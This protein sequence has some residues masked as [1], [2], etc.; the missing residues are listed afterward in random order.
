MINYLVIPTGGFMAVPSIAGNV[1]AL[2][3]YLKNLEIAITQTHQCIDQGKFYPARDILNAEQN[4]LAR[5]EVACGYPIPQARER[6]AACYKRLGSAAQL[7]YAQATA[8]TAR[9]LIVKYDAGM[10]NTIELRGSAKANF[11]WEQGKALIFK[12]ND[13]WETDLPAR[14]AFEYK[15]TLRKTDGSVQWEDLPGNGNR[16]CSADLMEQTIFPIFDLL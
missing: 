16:T 3:Y 6:I 8:P 12:G 1:T 7:A 10:G 4:K 2:G 9:R 5:F 11:S 14:E 15:V 13:H